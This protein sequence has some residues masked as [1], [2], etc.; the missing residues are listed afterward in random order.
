MIN[1][2]LTLLK[3]N[4]HE[5]ISPVAYVFCAFGPIKAAL[6]FVVYVSCTHS[7]HRWFLRTILFPSTI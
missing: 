4:L 5:I 3:S 6:H 1:S 7:F 2:M